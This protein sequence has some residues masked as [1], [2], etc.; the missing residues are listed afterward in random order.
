M[1]VD[2]LRDEKKLIAYYES[3]LTQCNDPAI[4]HF[5]SEIIATHGLL[6]GRIIEQ[7][8]VIRANSEVLDDIMTSFDS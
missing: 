7:L 4:K 3:I 8:N 6:V 5:V 1:L 2:A